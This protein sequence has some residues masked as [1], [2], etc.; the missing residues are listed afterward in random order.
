MHP[1]LGRVL[2]H[3]LTRL[4]LSLLLLGLLL[5][6]VFALTPFLGVPGGRGQGQQVLDEGREALA[7]V[8]ALLLVGRWVERRGP[9]ALGFPLRGAGRELGAG[10]ALGGGLM[11]AVVGALALAGWYRAVDTGE[12]P[13][14]E[15]RDALAWAAIYAAVAVEEEVQFRGILFRLVEEWLGSGPALLLSSA[16]FGF[17]HH[18]NAGAT[19][20]S[21]VAIALEAGLL[22]GACYMLTRSLWFATAVH[23]AWNWVQGALLGVPVSGTFVEGALDGQLRGPEVWTG[24]AFGVEASALTV[25]LTTTAGVALLVLAVRRGEWRPLLHHR[26]TVRAR[27]QH[28]SP[29]PLPMG[30][31]RR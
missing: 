19:V 25:L 11:L 3:P 6:A 31:G 4:L 18:Q 5:W 8:L 28:A 24:G 27:A 22:L 9:A 26:R 23:L 12:A 17:A 21:S 16:L 13:A 7:S 10:V 29:A 1:T 2:R 15:A 20:F 30:E 14:Q